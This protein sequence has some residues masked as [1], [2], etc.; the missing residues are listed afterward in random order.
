MD[1]RERVEVR[2]AAEL[3]GWLEANHGRS[4]TV[5]LIRY[6]KHCG[7]RYLPVGEMVRE[8]LSFGWIDSRLRR[9]DADRVMQMIS[10][11]K[12]GSIWSAVNKRLVEELEATGRMEP[13]GRAVIDRARDDGSW[14]LLDDIEALIEPDDLAAALDANPEARRHYDA[15]PGSVKK[16]VLWWVK[17]A[18][19]PSTRARRIE[20]SVAAA[21][22]NEPP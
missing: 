14:S 6:K 15:F 18:K 19:R 8:L 16:T 5:W 20:R 17:S 1:D 3:R 7:D 22:R 12:P 10:P 21:E 9:L 13:P 4:D 11:R 2:S